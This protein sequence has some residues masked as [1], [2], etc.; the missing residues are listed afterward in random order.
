M[1]KESMSSMKLKLNQLRVEKKLLVSELR[2]LKDLGV[3]QGP[4][5]TPAVTVSK[6]RKI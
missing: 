5:S 6:N 4:I 2:T 1:W 3:Y